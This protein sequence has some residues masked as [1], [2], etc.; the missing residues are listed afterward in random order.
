MTT[1]L[2]NL[3]IHSEYDGTDE[4]VI[5]DGSGLPVSHIGSLSFASPSCIFHLRDTLCVPTIKKHL[6]SVHHFTKQNNVYFEFHPSHFFVNDRITGATLLKGE[7]EDGV[8]P[9]PE[10]MATVSKPAITYVHERTTTDGWHKRLGPPSPK[11]VQHLIRTFSLPTNK[12]LKKIKKIKNY[13]FVFH[14][15]KIKP[16]GKC[17]NLMA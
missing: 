13:L 9:L 14:V 17:S 2:S 7:C 12:K 10:T 11:I 5:G 3:S 15:H 4:V 8:Y 1:D 16:T 6:I